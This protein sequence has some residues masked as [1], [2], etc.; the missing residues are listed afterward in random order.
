M[1]VISLG[2]GVQ[3][4]TIAAMVALGEL[5]PVDY[6]IH[7]D[8]LHESELTYDFAQRWTPW[9]E[10]HG[11]RVITVKNPTGGIW[12]I[13]KRPGQTHVPAFTKSQRGDDGQLRRSCTHRWKI[14]PMRRWLQANRAGEPVEQWIGISL[15]EWQRMKDSD[16][17]YIKHRWPLIEHKMSRIDCTRWLVTQGIELPPR[18]ACTFCPFHNT[19]EWRRIQSNQADWS[20]AVRVDEALRNLRPP[21]ELYIHP[22]RKP[23]EE[24]DLRTPEEKGQLSLWDQECSGICGV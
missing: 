20:E 15:D 13:M 12:S 4:F 7:A 17:S 16:V 8:T 3:S 1:K 14:V 18:S 5:E 24:V 9:L 11:V 19:E 6:A 10:E 2:W 23:L 21:W 22:S